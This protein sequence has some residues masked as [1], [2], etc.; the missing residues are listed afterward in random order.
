MAETYNRYYVKSVLIL[1]SLLFEVLRDHR[2][3]TPPRE[4]FSPRPSEIAHI[5]GSEV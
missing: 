5:A 4:K 3:R 1:P 2:V